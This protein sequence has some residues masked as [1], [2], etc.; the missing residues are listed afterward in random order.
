M[1]VVRPTSM[2]YLFIII[3]DPDGALRRRPHTAAAVRQNARF[4]LVFVF[5]ICTRT[6]G[7]LMSHVYILCVHEHM[8]Y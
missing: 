4:L 5:H 3:I 7:V 8:T 1:N 2:I 6:Y